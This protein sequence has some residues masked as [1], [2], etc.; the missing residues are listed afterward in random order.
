MKKNSIFAQDIEPKILSH[1]F[2][3][4]TTEAIVC[5]VV[6]LI[7]PKSV[8]NAW[9]LGYSLNR[10]L[11]ISIM[12]FISVALGTLA[13]GL[14]K[15]NELQEK[16]FLVLKNLRQSEK[17]LEIILNVLSVFLLL[18]VFLLVLWGVTKDKFYLA[19][20]TRFGPVI[21][22]FTL[23]VL[24]TLWLFLL[25]YSGNRKMLWYWSLLLGG[26]LVFLQ[27]WALIINNKIDQPLLIGL[28]LYTTYYTQFVFRKNFKL[29]S[30]KSWVLA[31]VLI[32]ILIYLEFLFIPKGF[33][34]YKQIF[35]TFSPLIMT[36]LVVIT[37]MVYGVWTWST[38]KFWARL[39]ISALVLLGII[40]AGKAYY[41]IGV[42]HAKHV[43]TAYE[44][45]DDELAYMRFVIEAKETNFRYTGIRNQMPIYPYLQALF[46]E[47]GMSLDELFAQGKQVNIWLSLLILVIIFFIV[48]NFLS[49][50]EAINLILIIAFGLYALKSGYFM[51][52]LLYYAL[53]FSAY[54]GMGLLLIRPSLKLSIITGIL[55][56]LG[57]LTKAS[58]LPGFL[59]FVVM[60]GI[61]HLV[62]YLRAER[63][64]LNFEPLKDGFKHL[65]LV[66]FCFLIIISPYILES[67]KIYGSYFY[68]VNSTFYMWYDSYE[69]A[70]NGTIAH[71]DGNGWPDMPPD[72][73][74][75][76]SKYFRE[77][78]F[79]D[80]VERIR[81][82]LHW[83]MEN[84]TY[85]YSFFNYPILL[86]V[87]FLFVVLLNLKASV[88][89]LRGNWI[90]VLFVVGY[91]LTYFSLYVWYSAISSMSRFLFALYLP[92]VFSVFVAIKK[93][94]GEIN[95]PFV[96]MANVLVFLMV[97]IDIWYLV[98][99]GPFFRDFGS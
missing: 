36:T 46:Y 50:G 25:N 69:E 63:N 91:L 99:Y 49:L 32:W 39:T 48:L 60:F 15:R 85:Q 30:W 53:S 28:L 14:W 22:F 19:Y 17:K 80:I 57:H 87:V 83:Q 72:E 86:I 97:T 74:P 95:L 88:Q 77:H 65:L 89:L 7:L 75:S 47:K 90:V 8:G 38:N 58:I 18:L 78:S 4:L 16:L 11:L 81:Y 6:L 12:A 64:S 92:L 21:V 61:K 59:L 98:S 84:I 1:F 10:V 52:E 26:F 33:L 29:V 82:G 37:D 62:F 70:I 34:P 20:L 9:L 93:L 41:N 73:I 24:H 71:G 54:L 13:F 66:V 5:L 67:K 2:L 35:L 31:S 79:A 43:N 94:T 76:P 23:F 56:G 27:E 55:L 68:N 45:F 40:Y 44:T 3:I 42:E 96:K 51:A